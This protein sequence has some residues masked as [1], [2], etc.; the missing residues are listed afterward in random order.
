[1]TLGE[2]NLDLDLKIPPKRRNQSSSMAH[3]GQ[4]WSSSF[5]VVI[6][7]Y[8]GLHIMPD[9]FATRS[10]FTNHDRWT[11]LSLKDTIET[12]AGTNTTTGDGCHTHLKVQNTHYYIARH[13][14]YSGIRQCQY[15]PTF[16]PTLV[17]LARDRSLNSGDSQLYPTVAGE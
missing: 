9:I 16:R 14:H 8:N 3:L 11:P 1:V 5:V 17:D 10:L 6:T 4:S 12:E 15:L 13:A 7:S 2:E